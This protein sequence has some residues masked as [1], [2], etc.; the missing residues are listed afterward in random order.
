MTENQNIEWKGHW[1]DEYIKWICGFAC[2]F[3][4]AHGGK[5]IIGVNDGGVATGIPNVHKFLEDIPNKVRDILGIIVDVNLKIDND[6]E[7]LEIVV[8]PYPYPVS[9]K[10]QYHYRSGSTKQELKGA[11]LDKFLLQKQGK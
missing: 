4:N 6:I 9:Y 8:E 3:A 10:G 2:G 7:Y 1:R 11:A 5:L